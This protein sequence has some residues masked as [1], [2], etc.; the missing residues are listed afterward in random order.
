ML[1]EQLPALVFGLAERAA[2]IGDVAV[3]VTYWNVIGLRKVLFSFIFPMQM[4][5]WHLAMAVPPEGF[6]QDLRLVL[7]DEA[8]KELGFVQMARAE[9]FEGTGAPPVSSGP[10]FQVAR[11]AW[12]LLFVPLHEPAIV[13]ERPGVVEVRGAS[14][15]GPVLGTLIFAVAEPLPLTPERIA[16]IR[17][18]PN[19]RKGVRVVLACK[20][21]QSKMRTYA[22][23]GRDEKQEAEGWLWSENLP[24]RFSCDCGATSLDLTI[25]RRNLHGLLGAH[26]V[27]DNAEFMPLYEM[28]SLAHLRGQF[29]RLLNEEPR[30]EAL[31]VFLADNPVL[32]HI[33]PAVRLFSKPPI[34]TQ[35]VADFAIVTPKKELLLI[36]IEKTTTRLM[37]KD[38]GLAADLSHA[39]DQVRGWLHLAD[40]HRVALLDMLGIKREEVSAVRGIVI[41]GREVGADSAHLRRLKGSDWGPVALYTYDD[42]LFA[43]D[44]LIDRMK[45]I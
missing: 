16:A 2:Q 34:L 42:L 36:E 38:G 17:A 5:S 8:G 41:A 31:Q 27:S 10:F 35:F 14:R 18:D 26:T 7:V 43:L 19:A 30:E 21:C 44:S 9:K 39:F 25:T 13:I 28:A 24:D 29:A 20:Q 11:D 15:D 37:K 45:R 1:G 33:F 6:S 12:T 32:L 40:E 23:L 3:P 22:A 4:P